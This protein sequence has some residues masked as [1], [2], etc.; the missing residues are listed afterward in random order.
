MEVL[1]VLS[2]VSQGEGVDLDPEGDALL[3]P[4]LPGSELSADAMHLKK[5]WD[6]RNGSLDRKEAKKCKASAMVVEA[7]V[8]VSVQQQE[9]HRPQ[10]AAQRQLV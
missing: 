9:R 5:Q 3:S 7:S 4:V 10:P 8:I 1:R 2:S 6:F